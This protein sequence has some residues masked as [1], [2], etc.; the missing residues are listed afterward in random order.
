MEKDKRASLD[1]RSNGNVLF[2]QWK[3]NSVVSI[4]TNFSRIAPLKKVNRWVKGAGKVDD[5]QPNLITDY[6]TGMGGVA[7]I[8]MQLAP[9]WPKLTSKKWWWPLFNNALNV[10]MVAAFRNYKSTSPLAPER[11][12]SHLE[13]HIGMTECLVKYEVE[14]RRV[15][16]REPTGPVPNYLR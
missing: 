4:G 1:H 13:F 2:S 7:S 14:T 15:R 3:D 12:L 10:A 11:Q 6:N 16:L 9:Y 5:D 8:D